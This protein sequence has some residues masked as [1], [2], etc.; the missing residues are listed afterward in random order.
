VSASRESS[1]AATVFMVRPAVFES[2]AETAASNVFQARP[3]TAGGALHDTLQRARSEWTHVRVELEKHGIEIV[4]VDDG[5]IDGTPPGPDALYPNNWFSSHA[6][7]RLVLYPMESK[8]RRREARPRFVDVLKEKT[9]ARE[10]I[11][12][13]HHESRGA[14]LE[15]T[16][17]LLLDRERRIAFAALSSRTHRAPLDEFC[18]RLGYRAVTFHTELGGAPIYHTNVM[19]ALGPDVALVGL[20][21]IKDASERRTLAAELEAT[22]REVLPMSDADLVAFGCNVLHLAGTKGGVWAMSARA[23]A[24]LGSRTLKLER[25]GTIV[26][27]AVDTIER[28]GGGGVRCMLGELFVRE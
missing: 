4:A 14:F 28:I 18:E 9:G 6:D 25:T 7:G 11:D 17:S 5:D 1:F 24:A 15:G 16:G 27:P 23:R 21:S 20:D 2:N 13:R 3:G 22:G 12:L 8:I 26:A 19:L 10:V